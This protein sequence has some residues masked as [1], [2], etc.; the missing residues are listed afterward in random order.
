LETN[1]TIVENEGIPAKGFL[2]MRRKRF[3]QV[4]SICLLLAA[5]LILYWPVASFEFVYDD[6]LYVA[7]N[8]HV[9]EGLTLDGLKWSFTTFHAGNWHPFTW[10]S[11]MADVEIHRFDAGGHHRTS[12]LIHAAAA[13]LLFF[14]LSG[15]TNSLW[16]SA[17]V[18]A[19]FAIHPLHVESVAWVSERK[20]VLSG[21]FWI[22]TMGAY[23]YYVRHPSILRYLLVLGSFSL[24]LL[25]KPMV[26]TLPFVLLLLDY[27]P[28]ERYSGAAT[29]FVKSVSSSATPGRSAALR[30]FAEK[31]PLILLVVPSCIVTVMAQNSVGALLPL[32]KISVGERI[33]NAIVSYMAYIGKAVWPFD[34]AVYYPHVGVP[35]VW[36]IAVA[37]LL[38][39][40]ISCVAVVKA[41]EMPFLIVGWLWYLGTLVPVIGLVQVGSQS[42]ADRYTYI[43]LMGL[44]IA[45]AWGAKSLLEKHPGSGQPVRVCLFIVLTGMLLLARHQVT[46]WSNGITL[47]ENAI[48]ATTVNPVAHNNAGVAYMDRNDCGN[49]VPHFLKAIEQKSDYASAY[50]NL[51]ICAARANRAENAL[52]C[53]AQAIAADPL[54]TKPRIE[55]GLLWARLQRHD[56]AKDDLLQVLRID[57]THDGAHTNLGM[58][59]V[60]QGRL[61][62]AERHLIEALRLNHRNAEALNNLAFVRMEQGRPE[63]AVDCLRKALK[64]A[65]GHPEIERNLQI[66]SKAAKSR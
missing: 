58:I 38:L 18:A 35:P 30:L 20:D 7:K 60:Q 31:I 1:H 56:E 42:M 65:P 9:Q 28:L 62:D 2:L 49:A 33:A 17:L 61:G 44:Y 55:R 29:V 36:E 59:F 32:E 22:L 3:E 4:L 6:D 45:V 14:V 50:N 26:V 23:G 25:S 46:T 12:V 41:R 40:S 19:L 63:E 13:I 34:L 16:A 11:H 54:F 27:W 8:H 10:L 37:S 52:Q 48:S 5:V 57:P 47:F 24:G 64:L 43:P 66:L 39:I 15:M 51:G 53:F 21:L